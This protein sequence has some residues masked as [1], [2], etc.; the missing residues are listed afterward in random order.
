MARSSFGLLAVFLASVLVGCG[1]SKGTVKNSAKP[2]AGEKAPGS[3]DRSACD[4]TH[5]QVRTLDLNRDKKPDV[6]KLSIRGQLTCVIKD[7][8]FDGKRDL[9]EHYASGKLRL[10]EMDLDW[11]GKV[12]MSRVYVGGQLQREELDTNYDGKPDIWSFYSGGKLTK[13]VRDSNG[14][15]KIDYWAHYQNG[16]LAKVGY[17]KNGDGK[18]DEWDTTPADSIKQKKPAADATKPGATKK[19][20]ADSSGDSKTPPAKPKS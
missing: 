10:A 1:T 6:W 18:A 13:I 20:P 7:L 11:D 19:A 16:Q 15:G 12:D 14:N 9:Y 8:N 3:L 17:D 5:G 2:V 4:F